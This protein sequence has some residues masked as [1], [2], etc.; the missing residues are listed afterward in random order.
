MLLRSTDRIMEILSLTLTERNFHGKQNAFMLQCS[1]K[2]PASHSKIYFWKGVS[3]VLTSWEPDFV[4]WKL[5]YEQTSKSSM[6]NRNTLLVQVSLHLSSNRAVSIG[7]CP[8]FLRYKKSSYCRNICSV[9]WWL[10][11][12]RVW[13]ASYWFAWPQKYTVNSIL[14]KLKR[15]TGLPTLPIPISTLHWFKKKEKGEATT[16][17]KTPTKTIGSKPQASPL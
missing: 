11:E 5:I 4:N 12:G 9:S 1:Q 15:E 17:E 2:W 7:T 6:K 3:F 16:K 14:V 10:L 13:L 8:F